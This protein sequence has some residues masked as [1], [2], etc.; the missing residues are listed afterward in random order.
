MK[1]KIKIGFIGHGLRGYL[2]N[3]CLKMNDVEVAAVCDM[4]PDRAQQMSDIVFEQSGERPYM[5]TNHHDMIKD[6]KLDA[7]VLCTSW[8]SH[9][10]LAIDF[11][12]AGIA[13]GS[14]V[15][16]CD[17]IDE[18]WQLVETYRRTKTEFM[19][20]ENCCYG[21]VEMM[22]LNMVKTGIFGE[23]VH[24]DGAYHHYLCSEILA[25]KEKKHYRLNNY[26]HRNCDNYPTHALGPIAKILG[27]NHG[28]RFLTL[29]TVAS[30]SIGLE[31]YIEKNGVENKELI[32][33][34]FSQ[35]DVVSTNI[36]CANGET[37]SLSLATTT[38]VTDGRNLNVYG[39]NAFYNMPTKSV[40]LLGDDIDLEAAWQPNWNNQ[41]QYFEKYD[42]PL[43]KEYEAMGSERD[44]HHGGMD[45]L[46]LR[47][48]FESVKRG[49]KPPIDVYDAASWR[50]ITPLSEASVA[51]G[52]APVSFPDFTN[53][54]WIE[55]ETESRGKYS[56]NTIETD[57]EVSICS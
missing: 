56:L 8:S 10:P 47:A 29:S 49:T 24:C 27:I 6:C 48:F 55:D 2:I 34:K 15:G 38:P 32:G 41:E 35:G 43:W 20:L 26:I 12:N 4:Y 33:Q 50:A 53:G 45:Y 31:K 54:Q 3:I 19:M 11:M 28:N 14:E 22:L 7:V 39:T 18:I 16:G 42:H 51:M 13:V 37:V 46:V 17:S 36:M 1:E 52:G 25:G 44:A 23:V 57:S 21:R 30:K 9:I 40:V 5:C